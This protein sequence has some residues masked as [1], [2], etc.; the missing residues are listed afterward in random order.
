M[1]AALLLVAPLVPQ[2][3]SP[4]ILGPN[5][6]AL[7][8]D[9]ASEATG[10][11]QILATEFNTPSGAINGFIYG[12]DATGTLSIQSSVPPSIEFVKLYAIEGTRIAYLD[13]NWFPRIMN[14]AGSSWVPG[15]ALLPTPLQGSFTGFGRDVVLDGNRVAHAIPGLRTLWVQD[16]SNPGT[17]ATESMIPFPPGKTILDFTL[18]G[19]ELVAAFCR[20]APVGP[21]G[22]FTD[23][24][25]VVY[26]P[27]PT[28]NW[29]PSA[30]TPAPPGGVAWPDAQLAVDISQGRLA[31]QLACGNAQIYERSAAGPYT[32]VDVI[33][34]PRQLE[35]APGLCFGAPAVTLR[36]DELVM[37]TGIDRAGE[38][39]LRTASGWAAEEVVRSDQ[40]T[41]SP[42]EFAGDFLVSG[43]A[44]GGI[45][46]HARVDE[47]TGIEVTCPAPFS[48]E[49]LYLVSSTPS[50]F[51]FTPIGVGMRVSD[52]AGSYFLVAG[53]RSASR[54]LGPEST[55]CI[56]GRVRIFPQALKLAQ[57]FTSFG[58]NPQNAGLSPGDTIHFQGWQRVLSLPGGRTSNAI[59]VTFA[60]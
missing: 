57:P 56:G 25:V 44:S 59:A 21:I 1:L 46:V 6:G 40:G 58:L 8:L 16:L 32:V 24:E 12:V 19:D 22:E 27:T 30:A 23:V 5:G 3:G 18:E 26:E 39:Y 20:Y 13:A 43:A 53:Y 29:V 51:N 45:Q 36:G 37:T 55:L 11:T 49:P 35:V 60:P 2:A 4:P 17:V 38:R 41:G 14:A 28:G 31:I 48:P 47:P 54:P 52:L 15:P 34:S 9:G 10:Q 50:T 7:F 42:Y 33:Q